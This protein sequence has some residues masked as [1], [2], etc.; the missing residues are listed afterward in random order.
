ML[1]FGTLH[2]GAYVKAEVQVLLHCDCLSVHSD[3]ILQ[4]FA[5][6]DLP[7]FELR[8]TAL[9][10]SSAIERLVRHLMK[11]LLDLLLLAIVQSL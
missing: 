11:A 9:S 7:D 2:E 8:N 1:N 10:R 5:V 6:Q 4:F 3:V